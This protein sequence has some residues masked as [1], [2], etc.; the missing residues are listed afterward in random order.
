MVFQQSVPSTLRQ[1]SKY[2]SS[3]LE[4]SVTRDPSSGI[5]HLNITTSVSLLG[6]LPFPLNRMSLPSKSTQSSPMDGSELEIEDKTI[7][8]I[9]GKLRV[10]DVEDLGSSLTGEWEEYT[11][12]LGEGWQDNSRLL[13]TSIQSKEPKEKKAWKG[14]SVA[15]FGIVKLDGEGGEG[16]RKYIRRMV[17]RRGR[18]VE[19]ARM[20]FDFLGDK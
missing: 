4:I 20:V 3:T 8:N 18:E 1:L 6:S 16:E 12:F 2:I 14:E 13:R 19:R 11:G 9:V 15:G 7:G 17:V 10:C 5:P